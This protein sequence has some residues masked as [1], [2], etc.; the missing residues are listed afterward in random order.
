MQKG[1]YNNNSMDNEECTG[2]TIFSLWSFL[3]VWNSR[4]TGLTIYFTLITELHP[5]SY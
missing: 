1:N 5:H 4:S 3:N 2:H